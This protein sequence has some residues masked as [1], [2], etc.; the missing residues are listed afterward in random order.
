MVAC[1]SD[2]P[3]SGATAGGGAASAATGGGGQKP[4]PHTLFTVLDDASTRAAA[5][6]DCQLNGAAA[7]GLQP[8][9]TVGVM[10]PNGGTPRWSVA[11]QCGDDSVAYDYLASGEP[12]ME[13]VTPLDGAMLTTFDR[14][15][16]PNSPEIMTT[17]AESGCAPA[18]GSLLSQLFVNGGAGS[19]TITVAVADDAWSWTYN[20]GM[21][22]MP[23]WACAGQ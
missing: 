12:M 14:T 8:D 11:F 6:P 16:L 2:D 5:H 3:D 1:G 22:L 9:G 4:G 23:N 20:D 18:D 15:A 7:Y 10:A 17:Y 21:A 13:T 19:F